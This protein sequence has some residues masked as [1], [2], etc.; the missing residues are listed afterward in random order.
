MSR[1]TRLRHQ[2]R[3]PQPHQ[4]RPNLLP[5][6]LHQLRLHQRRPRLHQHR[7]TD[8]PFQQPLKAEAQPTGVK[9]GGLSFLCRLIRIPQDRAVIEKLCL[10]WNKR[11][12]EVLMDGSNR[13]SVRSLKS[14][15]PIPPECGFFAPSRL[16]GL[17]IGL[18]SRD[19]LDRDLIEQMAAGTGLRLARLQRAG[20]PPI[21]VLLQQRP[22]K[23]AIM[24]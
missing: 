10:A 21:G 24:V 12:A 7:P 20:L 22:G 11:L 9:A 13:P 14:P 16:G 3:R 4:P 8:R 19:G 23:L 2:H 5:H 18:P 15:L 1:S 17:A 6:R